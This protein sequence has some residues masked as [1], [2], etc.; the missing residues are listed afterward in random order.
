MHTQSTA[1]I[2][3]LEQEFSTFRRELDGYHHDH[4]PMERLEHLETRVVAMELD[5]HRDD[6]QPRERVE[7][8]ETRVIAIDDTNPL[9]DVGILGPRCM[10][11]Y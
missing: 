7:H 1:R 2:V 9:R 8:L 3:S 6:H 11:T 10:L 5:G 4:Q